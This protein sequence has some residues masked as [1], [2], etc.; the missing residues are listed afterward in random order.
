M[1]NL[2]SPFF[3]ETF[4]RSNIVCLWLHLCEESI[5]F[6][7]FIEIEKFSKSVVYIYTHENC[8][9][10]YRNEEIIFQALF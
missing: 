1:N 5:K 2:F 7:F 3:E 4:I 6:Y 9:K 10:C 8:E